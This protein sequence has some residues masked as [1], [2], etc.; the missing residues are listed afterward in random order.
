[1]KLEPFFLRAARL[2]TVSVALLLAGCGMKGPLQHPA[3]P[4]ADAELATPPTVSPAPSPPA[5]PAGP[6]Q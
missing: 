4:P 1:M 6:R 5:T 2:I 3:P